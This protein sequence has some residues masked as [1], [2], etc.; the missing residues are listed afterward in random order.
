MLTAI[1][2][3]VLGFYLYDQRAHWIAHYALRPLPMLGIAALVVATLGLRASANQ[4]LFGRLRVHAHWRDWFG[5]VAVNS[6]SNYLPLSAGLVAK[7]FYLKRVHSLPYSEF[8]VGQLALLLLVV[9]SNGVFGGLTVL[10]F[11][12]TG[13]GWVA[14]GFAAMCATGALVFLP[15]R[16]TRV[17]T[18][19][20][21]PWDDVAVRAIRAAAPSVIPIQ[22][23]V[24]IATA[25]SLRLGFA[26]G[27]ADV[28][29]APCLIFSAATVITR[30]V[31]ITPGALGIREFL[32]G[33]L[34][35]LTGFELQDAVIA[36]TLTRVAEMGVI[37]LLGSAYTYRLTGQVASTFE[38]SETEPSAASEPDPRER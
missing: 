16:A 34:A 17:L 36:S 7:A 25:A 33:G 15:A 20:R 22:L 12:S 10:L 13:V 8:A 19:A 35:V 31:A 26:L 27:D 5:L 32:V 29:F 11:G 30:V 23:G 6:F 28:G 21:L 2:V 9:G 4:Q 24:L 14:A 1:A 37:F 18:R 38:P 3:G